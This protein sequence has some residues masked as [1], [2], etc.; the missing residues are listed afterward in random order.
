MLTVSRSKRKGKCMPD[1][2]P[3]AVVFMDRVHD[4]HGN[5]VYDTWIDS[6]SSVWFDYGAGI[7]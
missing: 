4:R 2:K 7:V 1:N 5:H 6:E 3:V